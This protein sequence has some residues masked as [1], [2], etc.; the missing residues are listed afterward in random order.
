MASPYLLIRRLIL[1]GLTST[2][3]ASF[4]K[5]LNIIWGDMDSGKSSILNLI[6]FCLGGSNENL[7]YGEITS[8]ARTAFL[9][10]DLNGKVCTFER[11]IFEIQAPIK[12][13]SSSYLEISEHFPMFM[14]AQ[15]DREMP[16]GWISD[17]ILENLGIARVSIKE[18]RFREDANSDRLSFR[19]LMKLM[20]LKQTKVGS[21]SLLNFGNPSVFNKNI[22]VQKFV[23][24]IHDD[25]LSSLHRELST[26]S[27]ELAALKSSESSVSKF[28]NDVNIKVLDIKQ[29]LE[30]LH[31]RE[32]DINALE[33]G[34]IELKRNYKFSTEFSLSMA[35][36]ILEL[37]SLLADIAKEKE[38]VQKKQNNFIL[39]KNTYQVDLDCLNLS[40]ITR[41]NF[42]VSIEHEKILPCPLCTQSI[43]LTSPV[44][45]ASTIDAEIK[46][47]KNRLSGA[48]SALEKLWNK[49]VELSSNEEA[50]S[51]SLKIISENFD[52]NNID[53]ISPLVR[54]IEVTERQKA[55][56]K[57]EVSALQRNISIGNKYNDISRKINN[58]EGVISGIKR[59]I[60]LVEEKL[61]GLGDVLSELSMLMKKHLSESGLQ[62]ANNIFVDKSFTPFFRN[63]SYYSTSSGGVRT[64]TSIASFLTR[65]EYLL[66]KPGNLPTFLM[67]DTPGQ[68][69]GRYRRDDDNDAA[70]S[71]PALCENIYKQI[72]E[73]IDGAEKNSKNCQVIIVDNDFP[74]FLDKSKNFHLVKRFSKHGGGHEKGLINDY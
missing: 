15:S 28:L 63:I 73:I 55:E 66:A 18:S 53:N 32:I 27:K 70:T 2:Y 62:N 51:S 34:S 45:D 14:S 72:W 38:L 41:S 30:I 42:N 48:H 12:V 21:D 47:I 11:D 19:D 23:F 26:E 65:L 56:L 49:L 35:K 68:N 25:R 64:I 9:E 31:R 50:L 6:D 67:I 57:I 24:N 39:L 58:K 1:K 44:L 43:S 46:S 37:K 74:R 13:F 20:Y 60:K 52:K 33:E 40:K 69:I 29:T 54:N 8:K 5:G 61:L 59:N 16:D 71:D 22:E 3:Q 36:R 10:L 17:F 7:L 4:K